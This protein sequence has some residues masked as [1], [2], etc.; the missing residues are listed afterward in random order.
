M[1]TGAVAEQYLSAFAVDADALLGIVG[2]GDDA[3]VR[4]AVALIAEPATGERLLR[5]TDPAEVEAALRELVDG[6]PD[7][8]RP[9]GYVW[10]LELLGPVIGTPAGQAV[11]PGRGWHRLHK[12]F[13]AWG[14][15]ALAE[16]WR[17]PWVFPAPDMPSQPDPWPFPLLASKADLDRVHAELAAFDTGIVHDDCD[18]LAGGDLPAV[19]ARRD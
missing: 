3:L 15:T 9:G 6:N 7:P 5:A 19:A 18:R 10:L 2:S 16:L 17:R 13:R 12:P 4:D 1:D 14:L 8:A 11:L